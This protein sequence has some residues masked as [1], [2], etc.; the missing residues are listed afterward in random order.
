MAPPTSM[1]SLSSTTFSPHFAKLKTST[2]A[3]TARPTPLHNVRT[4]AWNVTGKKIATGAADRTLRVWDPERPKTQDSTEL[5]GHQGPIERVAFSPASDTEL[6]TCSADG[7][8]R[9]WDLRKNTPAVVSDLKLRGEPFTLAWK[10]NG[11]DLLVGMKNDTFAVVS[12][13]TTKVV[14]THK[15]DVQSNQTV[16]GWAGKHIFV[17]TGDG[18]VKIMRYPSFELIHELN[19][20]TSSCYTLCMSPTGK[21]LAVGGGDAL[22]SLWDTEE[23]ICVRT[24]DDMTGPVRSVDFSFDGS[25]VVG[26]SDEGNR[27]SIAHTETGEY[28]HHID[29]THPAPCVQW[30]PNRYA[31]A[32]SADTQGLKIVGG[33]TPS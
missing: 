31:L 22:I 29:T 12:R 19:A 10:P 13:S 18:R 27:L 16:F 5:R 7:L 20:H 33:I 11:D 17:T 8:L 4:L 30:H 25:F 2:Y 23:W 21:Y 15:Q 26:G 14:A 6:A 32:Y 24:F 1:W 9:I 28:V 3:D